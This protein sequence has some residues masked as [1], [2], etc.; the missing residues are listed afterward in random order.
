MKLK[1]G[2]KVKVIA[3]RDTGREG[4]IERIYEKTNRIVI[5]DINKFKKN[6]KKSEKMPQGGIIEVPRPLDVSKVALI[7]PKCGKTT[8]VGY[9]V[10][11]GKKNRICKKCKSIL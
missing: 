11:K 8:R 1:K 10:K 4:S 5:P 7:C 2:D 9:E 6:V 3:G